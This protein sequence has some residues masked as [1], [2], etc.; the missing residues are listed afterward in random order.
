MRVQ[1]PRESNIMLF[2]QILI[3]VNM[4]GNVKLKRSNYN[5]IVK[6][7]KAFHLVKGTVKTIGIETDG[8]LSYVVI[9]TVE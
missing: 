8:P 4:R 5:G 2:E 7:I 3:N 6:A 9:E 1:I